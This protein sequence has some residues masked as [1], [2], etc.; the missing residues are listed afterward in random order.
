MSHRLVKGDAKDLQGKA[1]V[2]VVQ[3]LRR[4]LYLLRG[5]PAIFQSRQVANLANAVS[6]LQYRWEGG[7]ALHVVVLEELGKW[8]VNRKEGMG[9]FNEIDIANIINGFAKVGF[10]PGGKVLRMVRARCLKLGPTSF[11]PQGLSNVANGF[12]KLGVR[13]GEELMDMISRECMRRGLEDFDPQE[14]ANIANAFAKWGIIPGKD[15]KE[16]MDL[17]S[18]EC[19]RRKLEGFKPQ[20][21]ANIANAFAKLDTHPGKE[22]LDLISKD[23][24]RRKLKGFNAQDIANITNALAAFKHHPGEALLGMV[25]QRCQTLWE[26]FN[27]QELSNVLHGLAILRGVPDGEWM[28]GFHRRC[29]E[30]GWKR[31]TDQ[32]L[33]LTLWACVVLEVRID[34]GLVE[35]LTAR[36]RTFKDSVDQGTKRLKYEDALKTCNAVR[37]AL[38][39]LDPTQ[40][41]GLQ[42]LSEA[43][44]AVWE[45]VKG[46]TKTPIESELQKSVFATLKTSYRTVESE[47]MLADGLLSLDAVLT[48]PCGSKV[49]VE[50][51]GPPHFFSNRPDV[52]TGDT[53]IKWRMLEKGVELGL[54]QGWVSVQ[55]GSA[56]EL[57]KVVEA[58]RRVERGR[59]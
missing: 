38:F 54:L 21:M 55:N 1:P 20:D 57:A 32:S 16:L 46:R 37:Q 18:R 10:N 36:L 41:K 13:P 23:C 58:M 28:T 59:R 34:K 25:L 15:W 53:L 19:V 31:F 50:V 7:K 12:A 8:V 6:Q 29:E 27:Q 49:G 44:E 33:C 14:I 52:P 40:A 5:T 17:I 51:D 9:D 47:V 22:L 3:V 39:L 4:T 24:V 35:A 56:R 30:V 43:A 11:T 45:V 26:D 42:E 2:E 48:L